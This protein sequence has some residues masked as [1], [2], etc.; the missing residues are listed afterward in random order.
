MLADRLFDLRRGLMTGCRSL[1]VDDRGNVAIITAITTVVL[2]G[3][4][5][6]ATDTTTW[7]INHHNMQGAA[8]QAALAAVVAY[9]AGGG[10]DPVATAKGVATKFG[11]TD[12]VGGASVAATPVNPSPSGY[13][14]AYTVAISKPQQQFFSAAFLVL[15]PT[16]NSA[17]TDSGGSQVTLTDCDLDVNSNGTTGTV[18]SSSTGRVSAQNV[19][20]VGGDSVT[21][22]ATLT[23]NNRLN[24][25]TGRPYPDP[26][27]D[28]TAPTIG[29]CA[30]NGT[31]YNYNF[32]GGNGQATTLNPGT[33]CGSLSV[34][35]TTPLTLNPGVYVFT[36]QNG[37][38]SGSAPQIKVNNG[39][40][41]AGG[42]VTIY[43]KS[44]GNATVQFS[45][46]QN[47]VYLVAPQP[48]ASSLNGETEGIAVWVDKNSGANST[49]QFTR[50]SNQIVGGAIYAPK[51][52]VT[53][54]GGSAN[55][56][57]SQCPRSNSPCAGTT[58][59]VSDLLTISGTSTLTH[60]ASNN[61]CVGDPASSA[62]VT[63]IQ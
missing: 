52:T 4:A 19:N 32:N 29:S 41:C 20:L 2:M 16:A 7:E 48:G 44:A 46:N 54:S 3:F 63:L 28:R 50:G 58:Q 21:G 24:T 26:Y 27:Q 45:G 17:F 47:D 53:F 59:V 57:I 40:L 61:S 33:Y 25:K 39:T 5:G 56:S 9:Q 13:D 8:D 55:T 34:G 36:D 1:R 6:L 38:G 14:T 31:G 18:V 35:G 10:S 23:A 62:R 37:Y 49:V 11:F 12:G 60:S 15:D 43:V 51:N 42:G 30:A 22:G